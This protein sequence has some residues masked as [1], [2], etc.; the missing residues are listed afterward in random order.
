MPGF[1]SL[2]M[3]GTQSCSLAQIIT[4]MRLPG[5]VPVLKQVLIKR[6]KNSGAPTSPVDT[7]SQ[8]WMWQRVFEAW[9]EVL[10]S[11]NPFLGLSSFI[12]RDYQL[13]YCLCKYTYAC[14]LAL[15]LSLTSKKD[16]FHCISSSQLIEACVCGIHSWTHPS[17]HLFSIHS[18][19]LTFHSAPV[20]SDPKHL[21]A[22]CLIPPRSAP[23]DS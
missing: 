21:L 14:V 7:L 12:P 22:L 15:A 20:H 6:W 4:A 16:V 2:T 17:I 18:S 9:L 5:A 3:R 19:I 1:F 23:S 11:E 13:R 8:G 10:C